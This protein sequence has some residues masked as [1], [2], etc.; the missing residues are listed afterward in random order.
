MAAVG[1]QSQRASFNVPKTIAF[2]HEILIPP[3]VRRIAPRNMTITSQAEADLGLKPATV[4]STSSIDTNASPPEASPNGVAEIQADIVASTPE[5]VTSVGQATRSAE[6]NFSPEITFD[7]NT[8]PTTSAA[9]R[10]PSSVSLVARPNDLSITPSPGA[11]SGVVVPTMPTTNTVPEFLYQLTKMLT[12]NNREIIEWSN[13][14]SCLAIAVS[15]KGFTS[16][17]LLQSTN[18]RWCLLTGKI[19][20]HSPHKLEEQVLNRYFRHSKF[21]SFQRQLNYFGFRKQAGKGKMAPCSYINE[22]TT[23][24]LGSLLLIKV[25]FKMICVAPVLN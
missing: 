19:E 12:D 15:S 17:A 18:H 8:T 7:A 21:A 24:E 6:R 11:S 5:P 22:A 3:I 16:D 2:G 1:K 25:C 13:G 9:D 20:V 10:V 14:K 23:L 4:S